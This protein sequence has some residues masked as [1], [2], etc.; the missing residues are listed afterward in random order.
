M[1]KRE[2][3]DVGYFHSAPKKLAKRLLAL[4][5]LLGLSTMMLVAQTKQ[6]LPK[7]SITFSNESLGTALKRIESASGYHAIYGWNDVSAYKVSGS[8]KAKPL[9]EVVNSLLR[10][11]ALR[12]EFSTQKKTVMVT[13]RMVE[14]T[15]TRQVT[16]RVVDSDHEPLPG[17]T[18][19][20]IGIPMAV[21][22]D[23]NGLYAIDIPAGQS[24]TIQY[25]FIGMETQLREVSSK[26]TGT[27]LP[28]VVMKDDSKTLKE[29]VVTGYQTIDKTRMAG[30]VDAI[31]A[32]DLYL[33][34]FN[35]L[36]QA[37]QGRLAG[38][39]VQNQSG[40]VGTKQK[41]RVRGTSTLSGNQEP[42][43]V[44]DDVIQEDPLPFSTNTLN[45]LGTIDDNNSDYIRNYIGNSI[46]WLNPM[47][48]ESV[49][50]LKDAA[51]TAIYGIRAANGVIVIKTKRGKEGRPMVSY[52][53]G[54]GVTEKVTY[55]RLELMNSKDRVAVSREIFN[56]GLTANWTNNTI[57]YAGAMKNYLDKK[58]TYEEFNR[59][60]QQMETVNTDWFDILF[61]TP[62]NVNHGASISGGTEKVRYSA[63]LSYNDTKGT[64]I[65]NGSNGFTSHLGLNM[66]LTKKLNVDFA[67]NASKTNTRGFYGSI[68]PYTYA[69]G[70][71]RAI[72]AYNED[73]S[74]FFY[75]NYNG[76]NG[77][78]FNFINERDESGLRNVSTSVNS[79]LNINYEVMKGLRLQTMLSYSL[80]NT[81]G[82]S[83]ATEKTAT[84]AQLRRYDY[85][86]YTAI[87]TEYK[88]SPLP[89]G[90]VYNSDNTRST[91]WSWRNTI[92]YD[93][94][95]NDVHLLT[96]ML[97][98]DIASVKYYGYTTTQYGYMH[99]RGQS[100]VQVP[101]TLTNPY[102]G[103]IYENDWYKSALTNKV[104][105]TLTNTMGAYLTLNYSY[106]NR[107]VVNF[108]VRGD[109]SNKFG[110]NKNENFNP[111]WAGGLRW[112]AQ[113]EKWFKPNPVISDFS[114]R[115]SFGYQ[116]NMASNYTPNLII[117]LPTGST[118]QTIDMNTGEDLLTLSQ[119]PYTDL[120][121]EKTISTNLGTDFALFNG[122][123][124]VSSDFYWKKGRNMIV[125]YDI[126][127]EY[128]VET[129]PVN[130]GSMD[131]HG[132]EVSAGFTPVRTKNFTWD[133]SLNFAK[134][135]NKVTEVGIQNP[136]WKN[137][138]V[139]G[140]HKSGYAE[141]AFWAFKCDGIDQETG[142]PIIDLTVADGIDPK[143]DP[144]AYMVYVGKT[145]PDFTGGLGTSFR[146]KMLSLSAN[147]FLQM[148]GKQFLSKAY[149]SS[150]LP[151]EYENLSTQ[152][153]NRWHP[154][155]ANATFPGLPDKGVVNI[156]L[157]D[158]ST[159][160][161]VYEMYNYSTSRVVS[162]S[163]LRC[164]NVSL[165]YTLPTQWISK[166]CLSALT[167][168]ASVSNVF[169][170]VSKDFH[171]RDAEVATGQ[172]PLTRGYTFNLNVTF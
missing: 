50:V 76:S 141:S 149:S 92:S 113:N 75:Q 122:Q 49:T 39:V 25:S 125:A 41:T 120:G 57:G 84:I 61:R 137:A 118:S 2:N 119:L 135:Y 93:H 109:A 47:D 148:G 42:V 5:M 18:L 157:P 129:M 55:D 22:T 112:N 64:A 20:V 81:N 73:G 65:G 145:D 121:W 52:S 27:K 100:F 123:V 161:D 31:K 152:L 99:D 117:K 13:A 94:T 29:V 82:M 26:F 6:V 28:L 1:S 74:L 66:A 108:S 37:L 104:T 35:S 143:T 23:A 172:Q 101:L 105:N 127:Q 156:L 132:F 68:S 171:G 34:G 139:G 8:F 38:V 126:P 89:R 170:I 19:H 21:T 10:G 58:I 77:Y 11:K 36:E 96:A 87:D 165:S 169:T 166:F 107:Y 151:S 102:G 60:V 44:V 133:V 71:N 33:N 154:G 130:G 110:K 98:L 90:G 32:K 54:V 30:A 59:Q 162:K 160:S 46:S 159:Y 14:N 97:G 153:L 142:Y 91:N 163:M 78:S 15:K 9:D 24:A 43:W 79:S 164:N 116:R 70:V 140:M 115:A 83:Y 128:G 67:L 69:T 80:S 95:F 124:R 17:V 62:V 72:P 150:M 138:V 167:I 168:G 131:N 144:T 53:L 3:K 40:L 88:N 111:V 158:G 85:G 114:V 7:I 134:D 4:V 106:D 103:T 51:A 63:S 56:R 136:T 12:A 86:K 48:I 45:S 16:G 147:F 146:Y 155:D